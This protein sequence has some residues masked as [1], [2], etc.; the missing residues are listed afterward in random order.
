MQSTGTA[1]MGS[2]AG[3][4]LQRRI[5]RESVRRYRSASA[6]RRS[7]NLPVIASVAN[8]RQKRTLTDCLPL[9]DDSASS[10]SLLFRQPNSADVS[11]QLLL[12][13][14][15]SRQLRQPGAGAASVPSVNMRDPNLAERSALVTGA[16]D[17]GAG[18]GGGKAGATALR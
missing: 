1:G 15:T 8:H 4:V 9:P 6:D 18:G 11:V 7:G 5:V 17:A 10:A 12:G 13:G 3:R 16:A 2:G 14:L